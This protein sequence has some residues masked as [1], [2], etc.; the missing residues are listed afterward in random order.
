MKKKY[1]IFDFD[2]TLVNTNDVIVDSWQ[3]T[4]EHFLGC[5]KD[6]REIEA[7]FGETLYHTIEEKLPGKSYDEVCNYYR[8]WQDEHQEGRVYVFGG[9]RELLQELRSRDRRIGIATSR[10]AYSFWNYMKQFGM[11]NLVD[12]VVTMN[13]VTHHKP[14]P[15][16]ITATLEKFGHG[17]D[18]ADV[19]MIGD[20]KYDIGCAGNAGIDSVL[21][22]WSHYIDEE[23]LRLSGFTPTYRISKPEELLEII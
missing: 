14:H 17:I 2:G 9:I 11:E 15:E 16:S 12:E 4:F 5:R 22:G 21:V 23:S 19:I 13:D 10:T 18:P 3:A 7:T 6:R 20:T 8:K 1:I